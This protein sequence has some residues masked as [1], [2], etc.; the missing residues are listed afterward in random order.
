MNNFRII[1]ATLIALASAAPA[2][3]ADREVSTVKVEYGDLNLATSAG[4]NTLRHRLIVASH[5]V[6]GDSDTRQMGSEADEQACRNAALQDALRDLRR[7]V[8][9]AQTRS[10]TALASI[11][12]N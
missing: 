12:A 6:C 9:S 10:G 7:V 8:A 3:A 4:V 2:W 5:D 1:A 11:A